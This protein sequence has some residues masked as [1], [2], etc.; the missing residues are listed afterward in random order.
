MAAVQMESGAPDLRCPTCAGEGGRDVEV[1]FESYCPGPNAAPW[2]CAHSKTVR[3]TCPECDGSGRMACDVC[4]DPADVRYLGQDLCATCAP[5][6][7][8]RFSACSICERPIDVRELRVPLCTAC[9]ATARVA[10]QQAADA[11]RYA[12]ESA[13]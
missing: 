4:G 10:G 6:E 12:R 7:E 5:G 9:E 3:E 8:Q 2:G 1:C 11:T 13:A